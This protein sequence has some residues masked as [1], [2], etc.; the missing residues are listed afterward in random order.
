MLARALRCLVA[1]AVSV[2]LL[3]QPGA[4]A[5]AGDSAA[6]AF[7][8]VRSGHDLA[9]R[10]NPCTTITYRVNLDGAPPGALTEV[11]TAVARVASAT[12]LTF[13]HAGA[14]AV[15]PGDA[16]DNYPPDTHLII[17]WGTPGTN[18]AGIGGATYTPGRT[19]SGAEALVINRGM[20]VLDATRTTS[21][22][23]MH[24]LGHAVGLA[25]PLIDDRTEIMHA[26]LTAGPA[27]WG[28]GDLAGLHAVGASRGCL[29]VDPALSAG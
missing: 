28:A 23:L 3:G 13:R 8:S 14:T 24:E 26:R 7:L 21:R 16:P 25:H 6:F 12:G 11:K 2:P 20:V 29:S 4:A 22:L 15:V 17:A 5:P 27:T 1:A 19:A 10:W 9:A 18:E